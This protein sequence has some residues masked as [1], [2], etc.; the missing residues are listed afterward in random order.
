[1]IKKYLE[2]T[3][4]SWKNESYI[5]EKDTTDDIS[6]IINQL[7]EEF[8]EEYNCT[9]FDINNGLCIEFSEELIN[10]LGGYKE[11]DSLF[12]M[13]TDNFFTD[14]EGTAEMWGDVISTDY[15]FWSKNMLDWYGYP[16][17]PLE[18]IIG[19]SHHQWIKYNGKFYD[20]E[21]D[22]GVKKWIDLPLIKRMFDVLKK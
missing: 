6:Q 4:S 9:L 15:G 5:L 22:K 20:A 2:F 21:C 10:R 12:E 16:P 8:K 13:S 3:S 19:L 11:D 18:K 14:D 17:L 1:M 7:V